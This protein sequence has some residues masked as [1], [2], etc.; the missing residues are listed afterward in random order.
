MWFS[1]QASCPG[2]LSDLILVFVWDR[3]LLP[4]SPKYEITDVCRHPQLNSSYLRGSEVLLSVIF[5][6]GAKLKAER[7]RSQNGNSNSDIPQRL[8]LTVQLYASLN[9]ENK[10]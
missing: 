5:Y 2:T 8:C 4:L 10:R 3:I 7:T 9:I 1:P 6:R